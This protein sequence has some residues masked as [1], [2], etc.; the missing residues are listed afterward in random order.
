MSSQRALKASC[1]ALWLAAIKEER[2]IR[3]SQLEQGV[4]RSN[5][6]ASAVTGLSQANASALLHFC[7]AFWCRAVD[8]SR[9]EHVGEL[10]KQAVGTQ[11]RQYDRA[12]ACWA[13]CSDRSLKAA[14]LNHWSLA[15]QHIKA[16]RETELRRSQS[17]AA[18][19]LR[20][21]QATGACVLQG[22]LSAWHS[23]AL[24]ARSVDLRSAALGVLAQSSDRSLRCAC[25]AAWAKRVLADRSARR[26]QARTS[27]AA[28]SALTRLVQ[29]DLSALQRLCL[30]TWCSEARASGGRR[31]ASLRQDQGLSC[32]ALTSGRAVRR[33]CFLAWLTVT[34]LG[35]AAKKLDM[36]YDH[37]LAAWAQSSQRTSER[38]CVW[39]WRFMLI[40]K[41]A[42]AAALVRV[43]R[44][45]DDACL[46]SCMAAWCRV[47]ADTR[48]S[49]REAE[50]HRV[51]TMQNKRYATTLSCWV[52]SMTLAIKMGS[53]AEWIVFAQQGIL[54]RK[55]QAEERQRRSST[56][57]IFLQGL[58]AEASRSSALHSCWA[59]WT[60]GVESSRQ[61]RRAVL[62]RLRRSQVAMEVLEKLFHADARA[63]VSSCWNAWLRVLREAIQETGDAQRGQSLSLKQRQ[64]DRALACWAHSS[65][66]VLR[67]SCWTA[68]VLQVQHRR[69]ERVER[70]R[71]AHVTAATVE[72][73]CR[74][75]A[76]VTLRAGWLAWVAIAR[77]TLQEAVDTQQ[78]TAITWHRRQYDLTLACWA[79][80]ADRALKKACITAWLQDT[81]ESQAR[82]VDKLRRF[83]AAL[84]AV[85]RLGEANDQTFL[86]VCW[87]V[88][89][90][91]VQDGRIAAV[92]A[93]QAKL[94]LRFRVRNTRILFC[95]S[96]SSQRMLRASCF[97]AW[98]SSA[99]E[100]RETLTAQ[101]EEMARRS[102]MAATAVTGLSQMNT[103]ALVCVCWA[104]WCRVL[105]NAQR[106]ALESQQQ[107]AVSQQKKL[108]ERAMACWSQ[109]SERACKK[110]CLAAWIQCVA[111]SKALQQE[112]IRSSTAAVSAMS[113][114]G[115]A[116]DGTLQQISW[117]AWCQAVRESRFESI[118][119]QRH[120]ALILQKRQYENAMA[121][122]AQS[123]ER[124]F[125]K[126][127]LAA[128]MQCAREGKALQEER[129]RRSTAAVSAMSTLCQA[130]DGTLQQISW[131]AWCQAVRESRFESIDA[132][133][134]KA[135]L[136]QQRQYGNAMA[137][138]AQS[139]ERSFKKTCLAAWRQCANEG[140]SLQE[141][142][143]RSSTA[144][145]S[146]VSTLGQANDGTLKQMS[147]LAWC[148]AVRESRFE[149]IE[150]QRHKALLL[151]QRQYENA[152]ACWAQ[153]SERSF[154][155]SCLAAWMQC[156]DEGKALQKER[157]RRSTAALS[158]ISTFGQA[159]DGT[160][161][162]MSW[163]AW[164]QAVRESR[165]ESIEAQR[166][167]ALLLQQRQCDHA[168]ACW[169]QSSERSFKTACLAAWMQ[170][171]RE[172]RALQEERIRRSTAALSAVSTFGQANDGTLKQMS[173]LAWCQA[174]RESR[175]EIRFVAIDAERH[176]ALLLQQSR[177]EHALACWAQSSERSFRKSCLAAWMQCAREGK[178]LQEERIR[179]STAALSAVSAFGQANDGT[180]K[181][182]SWLAWCQAVRE[183]R[184][185][186]IDAQ[187][188]KA[189][190][191]QQRQYKHA[192]ACWAQSSER[193][194]KQSCLSAWMQCAR[195]GKALQE[196]R[197]RSSAA[198][199]SAMSTFAEAND[200]T[201][202]QMSWLAWC[203]AVRESRFESIGAQR[204]KA[205][206]LQ[207]RQ[208]EHAMACWARSSERTLKNACLAA[209]LENV[210]DGKALQEERIR[211]STAAVGA[212][213]TFAQ[214]NDGTLK[215]MSW[216]AWCQV[217]REATQASQRHRD[218]KLQQ[219]RFDSALVS[220]ARSCQR[221]LKKSSVQAWQ[222]VVEEQRK[223]EQLRLGLHRSFLFWESECHFVQLRSCFGVWSREAQ[224]AGGRARRSELAVDALTRFCKQGSAL[225]KA[226][227]PKAS[228]SALLPSQLVALAA[229]TQQP[230]SPQCLVEAVL[231]NCA[232]TE[233]LQQ[234]QQQAKTL[235][236]RCAAD[237]SEMMAEREARF[238]AD[239][240]NKAVGQLPA[241]AVSGV[242]SLQQSSPS[243][244]GAPAEAYRAETRRLG[245]VQS[246]LAEELQPLVDE[247]RAGIDHVVGDS[248]SILTMLLADTVGFQTAPPAA[249]ALVAAATKGPSPATVRNGNFPAGG[250]SFRPPPPPPGAP[251]TAA[252]APPSP[253][254]P[255]T[256]P[257]P[258]A[259]AAPADHAPEEESQ[260]QQQQESSK[261]SR[262]ESDLKFKRGISDAFR[263]LQAALPALRRQ[264][265]NAA[266]GQEVS[267]LAL[268]DPPQEPL[269]MPS[270]PVTQSLPQRS[271][272]PPPSDL[273][274]ERRSPRLLSPQQPAPATSAPA[275]RRPAAAFD[276][277]AAAGANHR[278]QIGIGR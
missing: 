56:M 190:L 244:G 163:L 60:S 141:E 142:R 177:Y 220:W 12:I 25:F 205:L 183:S 153:S 239:N 186:S 248:K 40:E 129:I 227:P 140:K 266:A 171:L 49:T 166:H 206:L 47:V 125:K 182:M 253:T 238:P 41:R 36:K 28:A 69:D 116:N 245:R 117:F 32:L 208:Y 85:S 5:M 131:L 157:I 58:T 127:C 130:N 243:L 133:R 152:M 66:K 213:S 263:S 145:L 97:A 98:R 236:W 211:R 128:W 59:A 180:L 78:Q 8:V 119:A 228:D 272:S 34:E 16:R 256:A 101:L 184:F 203:Q 249:P 24:K 105:D 195:E 14:C 27:T 160:L 17:A 100:G 79:H 237:L 230:C 93:D 123:S 147:W 53:F 221:G 63:A 121:C 167:K 143:I 88:W 84:S 122:W 162:Q 262:H 112:R 144:A 235:A 212:M 19:L 18:A 65:R 72:K 229:S 136:L 251:T 276:A 134:H 181:Q 176:K 35:C 2:E 38:L 178:A 271:A 233:Q 80:S 90:S 107:Q 45:R 20:L 197:I 87:V 274:Q 194:F 260:Q 104:T 257:P 231:R 196:E 9:W 61:Q 86:H 54:M 4:R 185:E 42:A 175:V 265:R 270:P 108:Y 217:V 278:Q 137:C 139:S 219:H 149:S 99:Q 23:L 6:A 165:F 209:W 155:K 126:S 118:E 264:S 21:S 3:E 102:S 39:A 261:I 232:S 164:C 273:A 275:R 50:H 150:A 172:R 148:Q 255:P 269:A 250:V 202:K 216:L 254:A 215:Q 103:F 44:A 258:A 174:V 7:W 226:S 124:S 170:C 68:W 83:S 207:Q 151:Q 33:R 62:E 199:L 222:G 201:L 138:W 259:P 179:S 22:L 156:V 106:E 43:W 67:R 223:A 240:N 71:R 200:G 29:A 110:S 11:Q 31:L 74:A 91:A 81:K 70:A 94:A 77:E 247:V 252:P 191:L 169:A 204:H 96:V 52:Q 64:Y 159:N 1:F 114:L 241:A 146:A 73:M 13:D 173:W 76:T 242:L 111:D 26:N 57:D 120:K 224:E 277:L 268:P 75:E 51:V 246:R 267:R 48:R 198:A 55:A 37:A 154:K 46:D 95:W 225:L 189:S 192:M 115:Q 187:R 188:H 89:C 30:S 158:A 15:R 210:K 161:K 92:S 135:L 82:Q 109:S 218:T 113:T 234:L 214:A 193:S 132:Q 10:Q 168:L